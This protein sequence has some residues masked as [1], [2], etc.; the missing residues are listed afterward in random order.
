MAATPPAL[1]FARNALQ[2]TPERVTIYTNGA[3]DLSNDIIATVGA[4]PESRLK[5]DSRRIKR[6]EKGANKADVILH[7]EDGSSQIEAY[8]GHKPKTQVNGPFAKQLSLEMTP[9]GD[10]KTFPPFF[11]SSLSG[12][13]T[14][15]DCGSMVKIVTN[16]LYMGASTAAGAAAQLQA[17]TLGQKPMCG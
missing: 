1:H 14:A 7:F 6:L 4:G 9:M 3:G 5:V 16:A 2:L 12:V 17:E 10:I 15:G 13:Y 11:Q 8:L